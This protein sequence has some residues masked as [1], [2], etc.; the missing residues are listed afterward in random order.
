MTAPLRSSTQPSCWTHVD[1][2]L[3]SVASSVLTKSGREMID[4][5]IAGQRDPEALAEMAKGRM[6][7]AIPELKDALGGTVQL[8]SRAAL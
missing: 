1:P 7:P 4:A 2:G 3:S 6:R 8:S 5:L